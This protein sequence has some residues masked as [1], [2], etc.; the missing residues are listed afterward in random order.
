M[1]HLFRYLVGHFGAMH[2]NRGAPKPLPEPRET[3]WREAMANP[4]YR[5]YPN[6]F[7]VVAQKG[8]HMPPYFGLL[9]DPYDDE[10]AVNRIAQYKES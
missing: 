6:V 5:M 4:D 2:Q 3:Y 10:E 8:E 7:N 9:I 1:L